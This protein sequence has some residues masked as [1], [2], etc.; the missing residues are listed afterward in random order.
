MFLKLENEK[1]IRNFYRILPL[2]KS[3]LFKKINFETTSNDEQ[4]TIII[5]ALNI[6]NRKQRITFIYD[7]SCRLIDEKTKEKNICG[8]KNCKCYTQRNNK[9][10]YGCCRIC[11]YKTDSG[12]PTKNLAC[13]L[14]NCSEV[15][16]RHKV[17][18]YNDLKILKLLSIRQR[19]LVKSDYFTL[20]EKVLKDLYSYS[21]VYSS[22]KIIFRLIFNVIYIKTNEKN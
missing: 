12:C 10:S 16:T 6:K 4:I 15:K 18:E 21:I 5:K 17:I 9:Y 22:I 3:I 20:R 1:Q 8:F 2:Y 7:E 14:F 13:K 11:R 19:F